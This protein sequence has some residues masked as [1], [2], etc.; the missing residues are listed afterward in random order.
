MEEQL[1]KLVEFAEPKPKSFICVSRNKSRLTT[2]FVPPL[3]F[4]PSSRYEMALISL[5]TYYSNNHLKMPLDDGKTWMDIHIPIGC[6]EIKV[7]NNELQRFIMKKIGYKEAEKRIILS[8]NPNTLR[9]VLEILDAKCQ[10]DFNVNDSLCKILGFNKKIYKAGRYESENLFNILSVNLILVHCD[11]IEASRLNRI[12]APL[13]YSF[14]IDVAPGDKI[15]STS[16]HLIYIPL[17]LNIISHMT[18]WH[19]DSISFA[20]RHRSEWMLLRTV[21]YMIL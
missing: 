14:F 10:L 19:R 17:T 1:R 5:E 15:V 11:V 20:S 2:S 7:F 6:Y 21:M 13:I 3:E 9:C 4:P 12:E 8:P 16:L 18:R